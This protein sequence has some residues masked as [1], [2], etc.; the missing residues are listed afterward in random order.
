MKTPQAHVLHVQ[1]CF[2]PDC[3]SRSLSIVEDDLNESSDEP[4]TVEALS[5][6]DGVYRVVGLVN[7]GTCA[8]CGMAFGAIKRAVPIE[9]RNLVCDCGS[10]DFSFSIQSLKLRKTRGKRDW[11]FELDVKCKRCDVNK[12]QVPV[13]D[14]QDVQSIEV[15]SKN[16]TIKVKSP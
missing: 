15:D 8:I 6:K 12:F 16:V 4:V 11:R 14:W 10:Q 9:L 1:D 5:R 2:C 3:G 13:L 7:A